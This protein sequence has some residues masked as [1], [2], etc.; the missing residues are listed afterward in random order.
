[1]FGGSRL[2]KSLSE[3]VISKQKF[4]EISLYIALYE[5]PHRGLEGLHLWSLRNSLPNAAGELCLGA[6]SQEVWRFDVAEEEKNRAAKLYQDTVEYQK[7]ADTV[8]LKSPSTE[9][10]CFLVQ[11][12]GLETTNTGELIVAG[13]TSIRMCFSELLPIVVFTIFLL[14]IAFGSMTLFR[15]SKCSTKCGSGDMAKAQSPPV[16]QSLLVCHYTNTNHSCILGMIF[17]LYDIVS[18]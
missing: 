5:S 16:C 2:S 7:I 12:V 15:H 11:D 4:C 9:K 18:H 10:L 6:G 8:N 1:M 13:S 14:Q 3:Q 17:E